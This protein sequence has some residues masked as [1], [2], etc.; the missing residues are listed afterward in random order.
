VSLH[1]Q[2]RQYS[3]DSISCECL[4]GT[5][6]S[7][8]S[9]PDTRGACGGAA[10][11]GTTFL[12]PRQRCLADE[13][14]SSDASLQSLH[15]PFR[16]H[17]ITREVDTRQR[18]SCIA[19]RLIRDCTTI[20][21]LTVAGTTNRRSPRVLEP[22]STQ[23][24]ARNFWPLKPRSWVTLGCIYSQVED[25]SLSIE[26]IRQSE[27]IEAVPP[28]N[29]ALRDRLHWVAAIWYIGT[30]PDEGEEAACADMIIKYIWVGRDTESAQ[31]ASTVEGRRGNTPSCHSIVD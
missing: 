30:P 26:Y 14:L 21:D 29:A 12:R 2:N 4:T 3:D 27:T 17:P 31:A 23:R 24:P 11:G 19:G 1:L 25:T 15:R 6:H 16:I 22:H 9:D 18:R 20:C 7:G 28:K 8:R 13:A 10:Q 5:T